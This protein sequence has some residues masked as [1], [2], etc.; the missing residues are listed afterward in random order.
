MALFGIEIKDELIKDEDKL[1]EK[2]YEFLAI[3]LPLR[4]KYNTRDELEDATQE[5]IMYI[6]RRVREEN[7]I[8]NLERYI[9]NRAHSFVSSYIIRPLQKERA[10]QE[11]YY[12]DQALEQLQDLSYDGETLSENYINENKLKEIVDNYPVSPEAKEKLYLQAVYSLVQDYGF[13]IQKIDE[14]T[15]VHNEL[16]MF[17]SLVLYDYA[18]YLNRRREGKDEV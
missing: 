5:T 10:A 9:F 16:N 2:L 1:V 4:L 8:D 7:M 17:L 6:L 15:N 13:L 12:P 11:F 14:L 18:V 3:Y